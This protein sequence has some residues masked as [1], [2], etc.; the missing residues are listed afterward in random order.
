V[1]I[2]PTAI[3]G[4]PGAVISHVDVS[5]MHQVQETFL[6]QS[7]HDTLTGLPNRVLLDRLERALVDSARQGNHLAV[8]FLDVDH[9]KRVND[10]L[11]HP[12]GDELLR[13]VAERLRNAVRQGDT[14]SRYAGDEFVVL[15]RDLADP[16]DVGL[17]S[18]RL[19]RAFA[20]P[21]AWVEPTSR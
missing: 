13:Q 8:A 4:S 17:L 2:S 11:G 6:H 18:D 21:F 16:L 20:E 15:F 12:A 10:S 9:F 5:A 14:L 19:L 3:D 1:R 7:L